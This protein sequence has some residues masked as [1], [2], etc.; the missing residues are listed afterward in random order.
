MIAIGA[1]INPKVQK[2]LFSVA[3]KKKIPISG[4]PHPGIRH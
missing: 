4:K 1:Q 2:L 3:E